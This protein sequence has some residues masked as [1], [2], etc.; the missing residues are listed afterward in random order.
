MTGRPPLTLPAFEEL[1][2]DESLLR[3]LRSD[4]AGETG[5]VYIYK[6]ILA[7]TGDESLREFA[8]EHL[9]AERRHLHFFDA[10]LP[11]EAKSRLAPLWR[12]AGWLLGALP[13]FCGRRAVYHTISA[14]EEFVER[15]YQEQIAR[16]ADAPELTGLRLQLEHFC[17]EEVDHRH[18][19]ATRANAPPGPVAR[20]W[21]RLVQAGSLAGVRAARAL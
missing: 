17:A 13:A 18:D 5:A 4:H 6:G 12:V 3:D 11:A 8:R 21:R 16:L 10:W 7:V 19:A 14:V 2:L 9:A 1:R 15:H 20:V